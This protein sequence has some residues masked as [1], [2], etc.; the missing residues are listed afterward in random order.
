MRDLEQIRCLPSTSERAFALLLRRHYLTE[1][2]GRFGKCYPPDILERAATYE[3][4]EYDD[5]A[6]FDAYVVY[7]LCQKELSGDDEFVTDL[8]AHS[9]DGSEWHPSTE[10][11][12]RLIIQALAVLV[13]CLARLGATED[14]VAKRVEL[15]VHVAASVPGENGEVESVDALLTWRPILHGSEVGAEDTQKRLESSSQRAKFGASRREIYPWSTYEPDRNS[16]A[17]VS[18]LNK[19]L[20]RIAPDLEA[21]VTSL[22]AFD[23][24]GNAT[25]EVSCQLGLFAT[26]NLEPGQEVLCE[27]SIL[28]AIRP[29]EDALCDACGQDLEGISFDEIRQCDGQDCDVTFCSQ[30]CKDRASKEY[31]CPDLET[32]DDDDEADEDA[33]IYEDETRDVESVESA[34]ADHAQ[35]ND[36]GPY[37]SAVATAFF[38]GNQDLSLI[39]RP[40]TTTTPEWDLYFIL[41]TRA[42][43]MSIT[44]NI[45]PLNLTET[46]YL[47]GDFNTCPVPFTKTKVTNLATSND[48]NDDNI[49]NNQQIRTLP[50]SLHHNIELPLDFFSTLT[51]SLP[52]YHPYTNRWLHTFDAWIL[53]T[54]LAKF[55]GVANAT[56][57]SFDGLPEIAA[58]H[59][60]WCL[61]NHSCA[62]NVTW[63]PTGVRRF[64]VRMSDGRDDHRHQHQQRDDN[65]NLEWSGI[66]RDREIFSHYTDIRLPLHERRARLREVLGGT[67]RCERCLFEERE[68]E[69]EQERG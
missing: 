47:W 69:R 1:H 48:S 30:N 24:L 32:D 21:R 55:R 66:P 10:D 35:G 12:R 19:Y 29:L 17:S 4:L 15:R 39:G 5:L 13:R 53:Q 3:A 60:G 20:S 36:S 27:K 57:S 68:R 52:S 58:V 31:H 50:F 9:L 63:E 56:Q 6:A 2:L 61:A 42:V 34:W 22:P 62:P 8:E 16:P 26:K 11:V 67:C 43:A 18:E 33:A 54:L 64:V 7:T 41:L 45:H 46:K 38:C 51:N 25:G 59:A 23:S 65:K 14:A 40:T 28:T 44:Q 49:N 37:S